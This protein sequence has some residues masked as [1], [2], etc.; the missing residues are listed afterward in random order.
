MDKIPEIFAFLF[1][2]DPEFR[3]YPLGKS[4]VK[5]GTHALKTVG[6]A[7]NYGIGVAG[8]ATVL[9]LSPVVYVELRP[10]LRQL[11]QWVD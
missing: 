8:S 1:L 7:V 9:A 3:V 5:A 2:D 6:H 11:K 4:S 10:L